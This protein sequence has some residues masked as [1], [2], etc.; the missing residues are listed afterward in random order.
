[1]LAVVSVG[2][3]TT[4]RVSTTVVN[5]LPASTTVTEKEVL[6]ATVGMPVSVPVATSNLMPGGSEPLIDQTNGPLPPAAA[7]G[8]R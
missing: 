6:P 4:L 1:M 8:T 5:C 7:S 2:W 3:S